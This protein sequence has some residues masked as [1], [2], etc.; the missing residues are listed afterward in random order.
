MKKR[1]LNSHL[2][3]PRL[4][5]VES[6]SEHVFIPDQGDPPRI[7]L[8][9]YWRVVRRYKWSI[10]AIA[11]VAGVIGVLNALSATSIYRAHARLWIKVNQPNISSVQYFEAVPMHWLFFQTQADIVQSHAVAERVVDRLGLSDPSA[12]PGAENSDDAAERSMSVADHLNNFI[13]EFKSWLPEELRPP[14]PAPLDAKERHAAFVDE[15]LSGVT[16]SGGTESEVL[17]VGYT[18]KDPRTAARMANAFAESYIEYGLESR[19]SNVQEATSWLR[20]R[21]EEL[22]KKATASEDALREFQAREGMVDTAKREQIISAKLATLT[23]ELIRAQSQQNEAEARYAQLKT[24]LDG[25]SNYEAIASAL[26][27][28]IVLEVHRDKVK[29]Q[30]QVMELSDRYGSKHPKMITAKAEF[31][32]ADRRLKS[33]AAKA[34]DSVRKSMELA[35]TQVQ[36]IR[37]LINEQQREMQ[38]ISGKA[39][40]MVQLERE[41]EANRRLYETFLSRFKES[42]V[43]DEY[44]V[45][46]VR[47][48]DRAM[49]PTTPFAPNRKRMVLISVIIGLGVGVFVAFLRE[50]LSNTFKTTEDV[51]E[52]LNVPVIG[53]LPKLKPGSS[54]R[55]QVERQALDDP[56]SPF[57]EVINDIRTAIL[58]SH[59]DTPSKVILVTSAVPGEGKTTLVSNLALAFSRR[60][61]TLLIDADLRKGRL[62]QITEMKNHLGLTDMLSGACTAKE[63]VVADPDTPNLYILTTGTVPPNPLEILSSKRFSDDLNRLRENFDYIVIDGTPLL[64]VSDSVV[65]ARLVDAIVLAVKSDD[66]GCDVVVDALKRLRSVRV[67]PIGVVLQQVD[68]RKLRSYGRRYLRSY[69]GYYGYRM[70]Q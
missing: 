2:E 67:E 3:K 58:F 37:A 26:D 53:V 17:V 41:V 28:S 30:Q 22:K 54:G 15:V 61:R 70:H 14:R 42:D 45:P 1:E 56:R 47:I 62:E 39:F 55:G 18:S 57:S 64:P 51:E 68:V 20:V 11:L 36:K 65:L 34:V 33:E 6:S 31:L 35:T 9:D 59:I 10:L 5:P 50:H 25:D 32:E 7:S 13:A 8:F 4:T 27:S 43:A 49:V 63:A 66:T 21:I 40:E 24:L 60:G 12:L 52:K 23:T 44:D 38:E 19:T 69:S 16:I 46:S 48:I 29:A